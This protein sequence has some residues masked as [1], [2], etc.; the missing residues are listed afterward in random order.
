M[1]YW[2]LWT[3]LVQSV[4]QQILDGRRTYKLSEIDPKIHVLIFQ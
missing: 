3:Y 1:L 2:T 4:V